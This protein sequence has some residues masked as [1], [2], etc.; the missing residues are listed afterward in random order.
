VFTRRER[1]GCRIKNIFN[2]DLV[3]FPVY[4]NY[5]SLL[6]IDLVKKKTIY[7]DPLKQYRH[8]EN[9]LVK[10]FKFVEDE[11]RLNFNQQI[12]N[13]SYKDL[14]F[15]KGYCGPAFSDHETGVFI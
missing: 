2:Y 6:V 14:V 3:I 10:A 8:L 4:V 12:G 1:R 9:I 13:T 5:W 15:E 7:F 11:V